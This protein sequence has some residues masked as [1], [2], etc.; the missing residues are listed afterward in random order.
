MITK[1]SKC[2]RWKVF[3]LMHILMALDYLTTLIIILKIE[4]VIK[5]C[6]LK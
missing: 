5:K 6:M 2:F 4:Y 3:K 1:F